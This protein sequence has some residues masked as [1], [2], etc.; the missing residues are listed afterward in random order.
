MLTAHTLD[1]QAETV[2]FRLL[3]GTGLAGLAGIAPV[4]ELPGCGW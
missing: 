2:L 3:R 1:D 4:L